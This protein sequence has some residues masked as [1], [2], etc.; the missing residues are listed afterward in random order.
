MPEG[1][2]RRP[3]GLLDAVG[4]PRG[5]PGRLPGGGGLGIKG[6]KEGP[7]IKGKKTEGSILGVPSLEPFEGMFSMRCSLG[8]LCPEPWASNGEL[9]KQGVSILRALLLMGVLVST[10]E[11]FKP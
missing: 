7:L 6:L 2:P 4:V 8:M 3:D 11:A 10:I 5:V 9:S 1:R